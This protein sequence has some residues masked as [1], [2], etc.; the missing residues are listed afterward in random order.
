M[1]EEYSIILCIYYILFSHASVDDTRVPFS[2]SEY[3]YE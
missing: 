3:N 1:A 2:Y